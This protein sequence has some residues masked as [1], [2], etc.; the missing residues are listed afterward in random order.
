MLVTLRNGIDDFASSRNFACLF[1]ECFRVNSFGK[2]G[3]YERSDGVWIA[4]CLWTRFLL[5]FWPWFFLCVCS[6]ALERQFYKIRT[7]D[8]MI[9]LTLRSAHCILKTRPST[10]S[11]VSF[12]IASSASSLI[13]KDTY[14]TPLLTFVSLSSTTNA[15]LTG[16]MSEKSVWISVDVAV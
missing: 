4:W 3:E 16:A 8:N 10:S 2:I 15:D 6:G 12:F 5:D 11:G 7:E 1:P 13:A 9:L 14:A